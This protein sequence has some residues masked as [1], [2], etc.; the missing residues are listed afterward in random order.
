LRKHQADPSPRQA[1]NPTLESSGGFLQES[2]RLF[3]AATFFAGMNGMV[4]LTSDDAASARGEEKMNRL[5]SAAAALA[6]ACSAM[7]VGSSASAANYDWT[8][9]NNNAHLDASGQLTTSDTANPDGGFSV[10]SASGMVFAASP[11]GLGADVN[12]VLLSNPNAPNAIVSPSGFF[13]FDNNV[14]PTANP[15]V[16]VYGLLFTG[17]GLEFNIFSNGPGPGTYQFYADNGQNEY[18]EFTLTAVP[19]PATWAMMILGCVFLGTG[20]RM[21]RGKVEQAPAAA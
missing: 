15:L 9:V 18:G 7:A 10:T 4:T 3:L 16:S 2:G 20:I 17:G 5:A 19:E 1:E 8:F 6:L 11:V 13:A 21:R 12:L 14:Y